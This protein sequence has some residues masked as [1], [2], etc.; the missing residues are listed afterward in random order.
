MEIVPSDSRMMLEARLAPEAWHWFHTL[1]GPSP[2]S[3]LC[4]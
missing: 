4:S 1:E 3:L 2:P